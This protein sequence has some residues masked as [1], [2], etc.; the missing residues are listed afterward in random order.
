MFRYL[1]GIKI[2]PESCGADILEL[3]PEFPDDLEFAEAQYDSRSGRYISKWRRENGK[4]IWDFS[5][6]C[7]CRAKVRMPDGNCKIHTAGDYRLYL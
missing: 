2:L 6:P 7:N 5:I 3:S 1:A 4:I